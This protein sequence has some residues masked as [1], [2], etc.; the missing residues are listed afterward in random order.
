[1][2]L[3]TDKDRD[4]QKFYNEV[5]KAITKHL[6]VLNI[7]SDNEI[8]AETGRPNADTIQYFITTPEG[9]KK[10]LIKAKLTYKPFFEIK[11]YKI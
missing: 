3:K 5:G 8:S 9:K 4:L 11:R 10:L 1:M 2:E 7:D 6:K